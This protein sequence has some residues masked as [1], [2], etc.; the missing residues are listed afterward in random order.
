MLDDPAPRCQ[1]PAYIWIADGSQSRKQSIYQRNRHN[2]TSYVATRLCLQVGP[3]YRTSGV[4][5][6]RTSANLLPQFRLCRGGGQLTKT[7][8][9]PRKA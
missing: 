2:K 4:G 9:M 1:L 7:T 6:L 3:F 8:A 5:D